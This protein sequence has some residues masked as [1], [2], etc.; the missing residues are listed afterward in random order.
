M[1]VCTLLNSL[2][3]TESKDKRNK[4]AKILMRFTNS[5]S[6]R[7]LTCFILKMFDVIDEVYDAAGVQ[8]SKLTRTNERV[9]VNLSVLTSSSP[10]FFPPRSLR[11]SC[12]Q[13]LSM[14]IKCWFFKAIYD[15][16]CMIKD[17]NVLQKYTCHREVRDYSKPMSVC[18]PT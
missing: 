14:F 5:P 17:E 11:L 16:L 4:R 12:R 13:S 15:I 10:N 3:H 1:S 9:F 8:T 6:P 7:K 18:M 2:Q